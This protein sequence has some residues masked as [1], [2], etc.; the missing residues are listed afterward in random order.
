[1]GCELREYSWPDYWY[2]GSEDRLFDSSIKVSE[3]VVLSRTHQQ[4]AGKALS[5][6]KSL[7]PLCAG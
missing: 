7:A 1:M 6:N 5:S 3:A 2:V 4:T